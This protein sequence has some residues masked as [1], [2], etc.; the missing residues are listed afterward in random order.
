MAFIDD[1]HNRYSEAMAETATKGRH[2]GH[3]VHYVAQR[4]V[5]LAPIVRDQCTGLFLFASSKKD[6]KLFA[7]EFGFDDLEDSN[8]LRTGEYF[9]ATKMGDC[10]R[11]A[12]FGVSNANSAARNGT[13]SD[14]VRDVVGV[15]EKESG[16]A[17]S[18]ER[19]QGN[20]GD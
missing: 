16:A 18:G 2:C 5:Q 20:E 15:E 10:H 19:A 7:D 13:R 3:V 11:R 14:G 6:G 4:G 8:S 12:L 17:S 9:H 1:S